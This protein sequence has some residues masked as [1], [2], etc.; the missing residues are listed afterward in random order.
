MK[1]AHQ[2]WI[3]VFC[4]DNDDESTLLDKL[5]SLVPINLEKE[6]ITIKRSS[7][8]GFENKIL[9]YEIEL[10]KPRHT[11]TFLKNLKKKL[12]QEQK[13][14]ILN[15]AESRLDHNLDFFIRLDKEKLLK[16][17]IQITD[18]GN[19]FHIKISIAAFPKKRDI[20]LDI[21]K[22]LFS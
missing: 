6:K 20:A 22:K 12:N 3:N 16:D 11:N 19:C 1:L 7:T 5:K 8:K 18:S 2:I 9:I 14:L 10:K 21:I 13:T 17:E 4:K 15:Q